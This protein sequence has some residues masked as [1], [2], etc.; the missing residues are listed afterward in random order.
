MGFSADWLLDAETML[1]AALWAA[2]AAF[3]LIGYAA[4]RRAWAEKFAVRLEG[5]AD[6]RAISG[7]WTEL[8]VISY[9]AILVAIINKL[10]PDAGLLKVVI[11]QWHVVGAIV[12]LLVILVFAHSTRVVRNIPQA[13][14]SYPDYRVDLARGYFVYN[15]FSIIIFAFFLITGFFVVQQFIADQAEFTRHRATL[16]DALS[17]LVSVAQGKKSTP[18]AL[19]SMIERANSLLTISVQSII[20]QV[21]T[22]FLIFFFVLAINFLIE[23]T[24]VRAAYSQEGI[25]ATHTGVLLVLAIVLLIGWYLYYTEYLGLV[26]NAITKVVDVEAYLKSDDWALT[27]RY[28]DVLTDLRGR[29]GITGF[30][31]TLSNER[32]GLLLLLGALQFMFTQRQSYARNGAGGAA[33]G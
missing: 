23:F 30:A 33:S 28:Y 4:G 19:Q 5:W 12:V 31:L 13:E 6:G 20:E 15:F 11:A 8:A 18:A 9:T 7:K 21:N 10:T 32:G 27:K 24:P 17:Q 16:E 29:Q 14:M 1:I 2:A 25:S 3:L 26:R 22:V